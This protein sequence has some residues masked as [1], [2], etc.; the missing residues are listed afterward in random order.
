M[1]RLRATRTAAVVAAGLTGL[2]GECA[3]ASA[4]WLA[5]PLLLDFQP[6]LL[7]IDTSRRLREQLG[8]FC[9]VHG[10]D[11]QRCAGASA[12]GILQAV[13]VDAR[14]RQQQAADELPGF[15]M[16]RNAFPDAPAQP[17]AKW[18][19]DG[20]GNIARDLCRFAHD[21]GDVEAPGDATMEDCMAS[22]TATLDASFDWMLALEP[23]SQQAGDAIAAQAPSVEIRFPDR[24]MIKQGRALPDVDPYAE[25]SGCEE[26][27]TC[28]I[29]RMPTNPLQAEAVTMAHAEEGKKIDLKSKQLKRFFEELQSLQVKV[30]AYQHWDAELPQWVVAATLLTLLAIVYLAFDVAL[31]GFHKLKRSIETQALVHAVIKSDDD[32]PVGCADTS[33]NCISSSAD[34]AISSKNEL[35]N[36]EA[37][38]SV[39]ETASMASDTMDLQRTDQPAMPNAFSSVRRARA[40]SSPCLDSGL[41]FQ[42]ISQSSSN[43]LTTRT[44]RDTAR[45][46]LYRNLSC[47]EDLDSNS[48]PRRHPSFTR[49]AMALMMTHPRSVLQAK[50]VVAAPARPTPLLSSLAETDDTPHRPHHLMAALRI[51]RIWHLRNGMTPDTDVDTDDS[52]SQQQQIPASDPFEALAAMESIAETADGNFV[53]PSV[54]V[55]AKRLRPAS[56][57]FPPSRPKL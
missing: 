33:E 50:S 10:L 13:D 36:P 42:S 48:M 53:P 17:V 1:A 31:L 41:P 14:C 43:Q 32:S 51:R 49:A 28:S 3:G 19:Q 20:A 25:T 11:A 30:T 8:W 22:L 7:P 38:R 47:S 21:H 24:E 5:V 16:L 39:G 56:A 18:R 45:S 44:S 52:N 2:A 15:L 57:R 54:D 6:L 23:C 29:E 34:A 40:W 12:S 37:A 4:E 9:R 55:E 27:D 46:S 35:R 26:E